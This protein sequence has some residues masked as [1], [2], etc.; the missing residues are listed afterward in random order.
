MNSEIKRIQEPH[1]SEQTV[2][3]RYLMG[4]N[5]IEMHLDGVFKLGE[6]AVLPVEVNIFIGIHLLFIIYVLL[7]EKYTNFKHNVG[8]RMYNLKYTNYEIHFVMKIKRH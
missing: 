2:L 3:D 6:N 4:N 8:Y 7:K 5:I 1:V